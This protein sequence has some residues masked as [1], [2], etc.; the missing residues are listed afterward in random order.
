MLL[1]LL[2]QD[3]LDPSGMDGALDKIRVSRQ[4][5]VKGNRGVHSGNPKISQGF[6]YPY[7]RSRRF[8]PQTI[9][10]AKSES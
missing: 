10:L 8:R 2:Q 6:L 7:D 4:E 3:I 1:K 9:T 5:E